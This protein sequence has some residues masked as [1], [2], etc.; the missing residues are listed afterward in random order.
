M[1][2]GKVSALENTRGSVDISQAG[3]QLCNTALDGEVMRSLILRVGAGEN[4]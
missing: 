2:E 4:G 3:H 1:G